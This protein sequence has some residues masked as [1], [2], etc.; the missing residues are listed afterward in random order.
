MYP[1]DCIQSVVDGW[2]MPASGPVQRGRLIR[3]H[4]QFP[5]M[6]PHRLTPVGRG[7]DARQH[8]RAEYVIDEYRI[9]DEPQPVSTLPVAG[10]PLHRGESYIVRRGKVRPAVVLSVGG[11]AVPAERGAAKW[12]TNRAF[13]VAPFYGADA[14]SSRGGWQPTFVAR[15]RHAEYPQYVWDKLPITGS[16]ESVLRLDHIFAIGSDPASYQTLPFRLSTEALAFIDDWLSWLGTES[17]S[18]KSNLAYV[19]SELLKIYDTAQQT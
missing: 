11:A 17:L 5:E 16:A 8:T 2:W 4:V 7:D 19:R 12:Q 1:E 18:P 6:K 9:G 3:T 13:L 14:D 10:L 15:I